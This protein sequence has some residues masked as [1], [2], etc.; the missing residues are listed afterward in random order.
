M[1]ELEK[2]SRIQIEALLFQ[3]N[4]KDPIVIQEIAQQVNQFIKK[5]VKDVIKR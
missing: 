1:N 5:S 4:T 3:H 2:I